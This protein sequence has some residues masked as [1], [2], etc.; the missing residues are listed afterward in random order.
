MNNKYFT[1][2]RKRE[3]KE[4]KRIK[5]ELKCFSSVLEGRTRMSRL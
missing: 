4:H 5:S 2:K 1:T 3:Q